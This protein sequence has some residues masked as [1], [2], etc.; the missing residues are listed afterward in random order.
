MV[1]NYI[2]SSFN[3]LV[4][5]WGAMEQLSSDYSYQPDSGL[6]EVGSKR[7]GVLETASKRVRIFFLSWL[8]LIEST[9]FVY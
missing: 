9:F 8:A 6:D 4:R 5:I 3:Q 2:L 1:K 7:V